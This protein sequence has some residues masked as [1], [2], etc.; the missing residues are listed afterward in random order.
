MRRA[1]EEITYSVCDG[2]QR[3]FVRDGMTQHL[4]ESSSTISYE[5]GLWSTVMLFEAG[6]RLRVLPTLSHFPRYERK[7]ARIR[8]VAHLPRF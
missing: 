4:V 7:P 8:A 3:A 6:H 1:S 5:V 2:A